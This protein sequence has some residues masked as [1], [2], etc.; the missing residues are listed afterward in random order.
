MVVASGM[1]RLFLHG[2]LETWVTY[3]LKIHL[4]KVQIKEKIETYFEEPALVVP[5]YIMHLF[6]SCCLILH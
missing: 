3:Q 6:I 5:H 2:G 4:H 1:E